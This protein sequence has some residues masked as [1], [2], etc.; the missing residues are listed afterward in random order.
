M[1]CADAEILICDYVEG[2]LPSGQKAEL[3][4][5]LAECPVCAELASDSAAGLEFMER[6]AEVEPPPELLTRILFEAPWSKH[7]AKPSGWRKWMSGALSPI[8][9][10][11]FAMGMAMTVLSL[12]MLF[13]YAPVSLRPKD[14][15]P[16]KIL[17][18]LEL[19]ANYAGG[20]TVK[21][22]DNLKF[23]YQIQNTLRQWKQQQDEEQP[24]AAAGDQ[25]G[26][27]ADDHKLPQKDAPAQR[28]PAPS[29]NSTGV[30]R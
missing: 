5:H 27:A 19:H 28:G 10:P 21:F 23:V 7:K 12:S 6:A 13:K 29:S 25:S 17:Q 18:N 22:Y 15:Q 30:A 1:N 16:S 26:A 11:R 3:E 8:L 20:R 24:A 4:L 2:S 14:W 9:Q